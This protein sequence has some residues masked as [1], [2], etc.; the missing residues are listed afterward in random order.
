[1]SNTK[2]QP[3]FVG[4]FESDQW[5]LLFQF[6]MKGTNDFFRKLQWLAD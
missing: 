5:N 1:M 3:Y 2:G 4:C 6:I